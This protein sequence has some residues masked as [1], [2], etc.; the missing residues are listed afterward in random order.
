VVF[1][2]ET[3]VTSVWREGDRLLVAAK[4]KER[5]TAV[6]SNAAIELRA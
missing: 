3:I 2:G 1:P 6:L 5:D 4:T